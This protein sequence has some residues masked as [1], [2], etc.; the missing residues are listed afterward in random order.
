MRRRCAT[1]MRGCQGSE[2]EKAVTCS[3]VLERGGR[4]LES[5]HPV[6]E[7]NGDFSTLS[8]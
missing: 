1:L 3:C 2:R 8:A 7:A 6:S 4:F 5:T